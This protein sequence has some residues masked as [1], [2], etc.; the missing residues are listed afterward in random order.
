MRSHIAEWTIGRAAQAVTGTRPCNLAMG[1]A[2]IAAFHVVFVGL[3]LLTTSSVHGGPVVRWSA[4]GLSVRV[5]GVHGAT[6]IR[7]VARVTGIT[8]TGV[9]RLT[10]PVSAVFTELA[11]AEAVRRLLAGA[12]YLL[13]EGAP[14]ATD[15]TGLTVIVLGYGSPGTAPLGPDEGA[16]PSLAPSVDSGLNHERMVQARVASDTREASEI[17]RQAQKHDSRQVRMAALRAASWRPVSIAV[18][19]LRAGLADPDIA[20]RSSAVQLLREIGTPAAVA[21]MAGALADEEP[22]VRLLVVELLRFDQRDGMELL[23]HVAVADPNET[24]RAVA[25]A[26]VAGARFGHRSR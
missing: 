17:I 23:A 3:L 6:V 12:N 16:T 25:H 18:P 2:R 26:I 20:V 5:E 9:E 24:V 8:V 4:S 7:E 22:S 21:A 10:R 1:V 19:L 15:P 14:S 13:V 11:L